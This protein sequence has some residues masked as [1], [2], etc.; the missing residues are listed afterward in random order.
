ML[1]GHIRITTVV[2]I[3]MLSHTVVTQAKVVLCHT[4]GPGPILFITVLL[5]VN[6]DIC[7]LLH[8][9]RVNTAEY[10]NTEY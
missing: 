3:F 4:L 9:A 1:V 5:I 8:W 2:Y 6:T 10:V 7:E